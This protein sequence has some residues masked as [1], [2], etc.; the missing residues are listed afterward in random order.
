M[1]AA[2][3]NLSQTDL[4][5]TQTAFL[6]HP[7]RQFL[8]A[9]WPSLIWGKSIASYRIGYLTP[10]LIG[11]FLFYVAILK[12]YHHYRHVHKVAALGVVALASFS[13]LIVL[14]RTF[15]QITLPLSFTLQAVGWLLLF[16]TKSSIIYAAC[17]A[18]IA[19]MLATSYTPSLAVWVLITAIALIEGIKNI[20]KGNLRNVLLWISCVVLSLSFGFNSVLNQ[21]THL[22]N[23]KNFS[24][25]ETVGK[26]PTIFETFI[27]KDTLM[28]EYQP[29]MLGQF[30]ILPVLFYLTGSIFLFWGVKHALLSWWILAT[31]TVSGLAAGYASPPVHF[32]IHRAMVVYPLIVIGMIA[33]V[34]RHKITIT[35][36][37]SLLLPCLFTLHIIYD[38]YTI[39]QRSTDTFEARALLL[40]EVIDQTKE[41][42][43]D[44]THPVQLGVY[45]DP[46]M[47]LLP[48][49]LEYFYPKSILLPSDRCPALTPQIPAV[50]ITRHDHPCFETIAGQLPKAM[51][52][53]LTEHTRELLTKRFGESF[54]TSSFRVV[55]SR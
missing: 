39:Y 48:D 4:G 50:I 29:R 51:Y 8:L 27:A 38:T 6:G 37:Y 35:K 28:Y 2:L 53:Q 10:F 40:R 15:E 41:F 25:R 34:C 16:R 3:N 46:P 22:I 19:T 24:L 20:V 5:Y 33:L 26:I 32:G 1:A 31:I 9:V 44:S 43:L 11:I 12:Y 7:A 42:R 18:W 55:V 49:H 36:K 45:T 13:T 52:R 14:L 30:M 17:F 54:A 47:E 21:E 23:S